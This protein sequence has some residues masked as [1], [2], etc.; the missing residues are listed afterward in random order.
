MKSSDPD[1][2]ARRRSPIRSA[3]RPAPAPCAGAARRSIRATAFAATRARRTTTAGRRL[4]RRCPR[5]TRAPRQM[6][7][8]GDDPARAH[9]HRAQR[10]A[11][12]PVHAVDQSRTRAASTAASTATRGRR[13]RTSTCRRGSSSRRSCSPSR[14]PRS[15][16]APSSRRPGYVCDRDRARH[17]HRPVPADRA[18]ME[19]HA[20]D[21]RGAGRARA[22]VLDRH[23]VGAGRARH[24]PDRADGREEHGARVRLDHDAR[25]RPRAH[26]GAARGGARS[27][28]CR[29][30][31]RCT[32]PAFRSAC[33][34]RRSFRSSTTATSKRSSRPP[35]RTAPTS[36]GWIM[37]R[38]PLEVAPLF[39][40][41]LDEHYPLRAAHVMSL[42]Q[43]MR[44]GRDYERNFGTRMRGT[45]RLRRPDRKAVRARHAQAGPQPAPRR[46]STRRGFARRAATKPRE[47]CS[48]RSHAHPDPA[49][50]RVLHRRRA[51]RAAHDGVRSH[52]AAARDQGD[53]ARHPARGSG[54]DRVRPHRPHEIARRD[55]ARLVHAAGEG[56]R[57]A[58]SSSASRT[59]TR[60]R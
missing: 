51:R 17:Q 33:W 16:C 22:P 50:G 46:R 26:A 23:Q 13:T 11:R 37:L 49:A 56:A 36:A 6:P 57:R 4:L 43:Q 21:P 35:P 18:R 44:G 41:W 14:T 12:H 59:T 32:T 45:G 42:V 39:R 40:A 3:A 8:H 9:D 15:S 19:G 52:R 48:R 5:T 55:A 29:R 58:T 27:G 30:C 28:G 34:S 60:W 24:R 47:S 54:V 31:A 1:A 25:P 38:L 53:R 2:G 7:H 10:L 20:A